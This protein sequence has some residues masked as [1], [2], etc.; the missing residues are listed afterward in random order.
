MVSSLSRQFRDA[1]DGR[2]YGEFGLTAL[3]FDGGIELGDK[4]DGL[5]D[6]IGGPAASHGLGHL[7]H[8]GRQAGLAS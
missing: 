4:D 2:L 5:G 8:V 7:D 3:A 6:I 1:F